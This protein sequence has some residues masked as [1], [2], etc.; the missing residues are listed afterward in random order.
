MDE[1]GFARAMEAQ[2]IQSK[3][4]WKDANL[5][6]MTAGVRSLTDAGHKA[7]FV[8]YDRIMAASEIAALLNEAGDQIAQARQ[9]ERVAIFCLETPFYAESGGQVG[10]LGEIIT[11]RGR[12]RVEDTIVVAD[13]IIL[14]S[15]VVQEGVLETQAAAELVVDDSRRRRIASNHTATHILHAALRRVLGG[16]VK[17]SGSLVTD[18][19]L[20]FD[21]THFSQ[22]TPDELKSIEEQA[23]EVVRA[24]LAVDTR[25]MSKD[26]AVASGAMA[27]FGEKYDDEVRVVAVDTVSRELC[28]GTHVGHTGVIGLIKI[29]GESSVAAGVRR[30]EAVT[31]AGALA[32][33]QK[34]EAMLK[35]A[36]DR[37]HCAVHELPDRIGKLQEKLKGL[38]KRAQD[39][40]AAGGFDPQSLVAGA[41]EI[42][43]IRLVAAEVPD[44]GVKALR[45][46]GDRVR[47]LLGD[48]G[49]AVLGSAAD[50][51]VSLLVMVTKDLAGRLHAGK[52]IAEVAT[53]AGG[54]GGGRPDMAQAGGGDPARL[55]QAIGAAANIVKQQMGGA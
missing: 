36:A 39:I 35:A 26:E 42:H 25:V 2:R 1:E 46:A 8:G 48:K 49:V 22:L 44:L 53:A 34:Q 5:G 17:Q 30:M 3:K 41:I 19:R 52:I 50:G 11:S 40:R 13:G 14:H 54:R 29:I 33:C 47:D 12:A 9:G 38:E 21:F 31:G 23:N 4:S 6:Q 28:G 10:D 27:L 16:H 43:G 18:E 24:N 20:R 32:R 45:D 37:L 55:A 51:K 7:T 15:A